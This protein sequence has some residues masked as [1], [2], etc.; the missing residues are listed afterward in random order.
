MMWWDGGGG[1]GILLR[2]L[3][4]RSDGWEAGGDVSSVGM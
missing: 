2:I 1:G 3:T 4:L